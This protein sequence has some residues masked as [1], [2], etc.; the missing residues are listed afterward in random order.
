M[1]GQ[2]QKWLPTQGLVT[3]KVFKQEQPEVSSSG[4]I[5]GNLQLLIS[6]D[7]LFLSKVKGNQS[8]LIVHRWLK[9]N[10]NFI[11]FVSNSVCFS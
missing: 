8:A 11:I 2:N 10:K 6:P 9:I 5:L 4:L 7:R 3:V 1:S